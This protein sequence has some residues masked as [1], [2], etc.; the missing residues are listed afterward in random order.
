MNK[1]SRYVLAKYA[2]GFVIKGNAE[3]ADTMTDLWT[4]RPVSRPVTAIYPLSNLTSGGIHNTKMR[5]I[6]RVERIL[7]KLL[8]HNASYYI[9]ITFTTL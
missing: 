7:Y 2:N 3:A 5:Q 9:P 6:I 8:Y 4:L 1:I